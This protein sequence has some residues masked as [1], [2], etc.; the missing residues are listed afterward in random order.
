MAVM[1]HTRA[2]AL[3]PWRGTGL[4]LRHATL[5]RWIQRGIGTAEIDRSAI[6]TTSLTP[7][8]PGHLLRAGRHRYRRGR[9]DRFR[10]Q[11]RRRGAHVGRPDRHRAGRIDHPTGR[12]RG[13]P[14]PGRVALNN[15]DGSP[16]SAGRGK[17]AMRDRCRRHAAE[18]NRPVCARGVGCAVKAGSSPIPRPTPHARGPLSAHSNRNEASLSAGGDHARSRHPDD[19]DARRIRR[20]TRAG[21]GPTP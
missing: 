12:T 4:G 9:R 1:R 8:R 17:P 6:M 21:S 15:A 20:A 16:L 7:V 14:G 18:P 13:Q 10:R 5:R 2:S 11:Y 19:G 3:G